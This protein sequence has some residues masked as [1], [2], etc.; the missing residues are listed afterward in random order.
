MVNTITDADIQE[1]MK[2]ERCMLKMSNII[3]QRLLREANKRIK[4]LTDGTDA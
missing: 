4:E 3:L 2:D 1:L